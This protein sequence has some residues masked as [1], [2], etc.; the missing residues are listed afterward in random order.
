MSQSFMSQTSQNFLKLYSQTCFSLW[1]E[2]LTSLPDVDSLRFRTIC[3]LRYKNNH[4]V[5]CL[6]RIMLNNG[7]GLI[8]NVSPHKQIARAINN[9][10]YQI[11]KSGYDELTLSC[12][13]E[14]RKSNVSILSLWVGPIKYLPSVDCDAGKV[15]H[16]I[17]NL[18]IFFKTW[19]TIV[20][21]TKITISFR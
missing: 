16:L 12:A 18:C 20:S 14:L 15:F 11:E 4:T 7:S 21:S 17:I 1:T 10:P 9:V 13:N 6:F 3:F 8:I 2:N 5:L 19:I